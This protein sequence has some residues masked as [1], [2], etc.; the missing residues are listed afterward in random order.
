LALFAYLLSPAKVAAG[1]GDIFSPAKVAKIAKYGA[2]A[3]LAL[4]AGYL[5]SP[6]KYAKIAKSRALALLRSLRAIYYLPLREALG[7]LAGYFFSRE[8]REDREA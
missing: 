5:L 6:A 1:L 8:V 3:L 2:L 4:F 7:A